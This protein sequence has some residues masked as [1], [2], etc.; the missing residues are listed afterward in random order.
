MTT[1]LNSQQQQAANHKDG[2]LMI[3]AGAGAGKTKTIT[4]RIS[5]LI[6][7]GVSPTSILAITFTNKAAKEMQERTNKLLSEDPDLN[8]PISMR[9]RPFIS[10]F[11]SLG[12]H[13]I[14][15]NSHLLGLNRNFTI[16]DRDDSKRSVKAG[17]V[18]MGLDTKQYEPGR[19]LSIISREKG[20]GMTIETFKEIAGKDYMRNIISNVWSHY[21]KTLKTE[22]ALDF[23]DLL[24]KTMIILRDNVE[25]RTKYQNIWKYIHIDEYQDTNQ[26]QYKI[27]RLLGDAHRNICVVGDIDQMIYSWRGANIENILNFETDYPDA[28]TIL[29]EQNYRST[30]TILSAANNIIK[31][32]KNR[33]EKNMFTD[34]SEG[35]KIS[36][37]YAFDE[38][39]EARNIARSIEELLNKGVLA[40][41][42]AVLYRANFQSRAI[43]ETCLSY[44]IN[45]EL[46][47][48]RFFERREVKDTLSMIRLALNPDSITDLKRIINVPPRGIGKVTLLKIVEGK[49]HELTGKVGENVASFRHFMAKLES[50]IGSKKP[51]EVVKFAIK[52]SGMEDYF[53]K[54]KEEGEERLQNIKELVTLATKYDMYPQGE[55]LEKMLEDAA[56]AS[57][58][59]ELQEKKPAVKLMTI[60]AAKGLEFDY[61]FITG[62]ED[63]LFPS[64]RDDAEKDEE[65]ERRLMYVA[66]T[67]AGKKVFLST[68]SLRTIF[69]EKRVNMPSEFIADIGEE[70]FE[71][72]VEP[73]RKKREYLIDF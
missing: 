37:Y 26:V 50:E 13:I 8:R 18:A 41:S 53:L 38:N 15:E 44:G 10:T 22:K 47:G 36:L 16:F 35:E 70:H 46:I 39:D 58:Q 67:R 2:P 1:N 21:E 65:E 27:A 61:V 24:L 40:E 14:K 48:T 12:V 7:Q 30:K 32:N 64:K 56:L 20:N 25:I 52:N 17:I 60:H 43:E 4:E 55:G 6:K 49:E 3:L 73:E 19:L 62:L 28:K 63:G 45:Y 34:N 31:K 54:D 42:I 68:A 69:G 66:V 71:E 51:S 59:D 33:R 72:K 23:D 11:H 9:E 29:L 5:N 57:D